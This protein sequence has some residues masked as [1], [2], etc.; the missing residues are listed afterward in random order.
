MSLKKVSQAIKRNKRFLIASHINPE[1]DSLGS[2]LA[3]SYLLR[4]LGKDVVIVSDDT[5]TSEYG[6]L[7]GLKR[8][9]NVKQIPNLSTFDCLV[10]LDCS[11]LSRC[12]RVKDF[13]K[14]CRLFINIDHHISNDNFADVNWVDPKASSTCEMVYRLFKQFKVPLNRDS[15]L[16]IYVGIMTDTGSFHYSNTTAFTH[17]TVAELMNYNLNISQIYRQIYEN[18]PIRDMLFLGRLISNIRTAAQ[19]KIV[20]LAIKDVWVSQCASYDLTERILTLMRQIRGAEV[21]VLFKALAGKK[22]VRVNFRSQGKLDVN[23]VASFFG[24][25]GHHSAS[26]ATVKGSLT[27]VQRKVIAELKSRLKV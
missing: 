13:K 27:M 6:F 23:K 7:P 14:N 15:A 3:M 17:R 5:V 18:V 22:E 24:G 25:G 11:N 4:L 16:C 1:G 9:K 2:Q 19:G 8:I 20:W 12:G 26:G 21:A 10:L